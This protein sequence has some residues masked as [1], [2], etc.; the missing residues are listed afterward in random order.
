M[1]HSDPIIDTLQKQL[2]FLPGTT[3]D[4][5]K[6]QLPQ[7][8]KSHMFDYCNGV[9]VFSAEKPGIGKCAKTLP[10]QDQSRVHTS[11]EVYPQGSAD[12]EGLPAWVVFDRKVLR[13]YAYFQEAVHERREEQYRI[14]KVNIYFYLEDDSIHV[15]EPKTANSGIPQGTLIRRHRIPLPGSA[16]AQHYTVKDLNVDQ[17]VTFYART[18]KIVGCDQFTRDFLNGLNMDPPNGSTF[19]ADPYTLQRAELMSRMKATRPRPPQ[20]SLRQFLEN[21]RRVL[22]FYCV[23][24]DTTSAFGDLRKMQ[25]HYFLSDD[26]IEIREQ[27]PANAGRSTMPG[28]SSLFL[29]RCRLPKRPARINV[30]SPGGALKPDECYTDRDLVI[31]AVLHLYGR[32]FVICDCD[33]FTREHYR[34]TFGIDHFDPVRMELY[35]N[36]DEFDL[37]DDDSW[38]ATSPAA[39]RP[40]NDTAG[41]SLPGI[42]AGPAARRDPRRSALYDG[43]VLRYSAK[44]DSARQVDRERKFVM[45]LRLADETV[46]IFEPHQRNSGVIGGKF[47]ER[48]H[49]KKPNGEGYYIA[50]DFYLGAALTCHGHRFIITGAD[51]FASKFMSEHQD[52][53]P[54]HKSE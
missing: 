2:P 33:E 17:E 32:P 22:R 19:P 5:E 12:A 30:A 4:F 37:E 39:E 27:V 18:F 25:L 42:S 40:E 31:G 3:F 20:T 9:P 38:N 1:G 49:V 13:F 54:N 35:S 6:S 48:G 23:W 26:T 16:I 45:S 52:V 14:R 36:A 29:R 41:A 15:S 53:F 8:R 47:M 46:T 10:G 34:Q 7:H 51:A 21:D 28:A 50:A 43:I 11:L 44:L 24:D